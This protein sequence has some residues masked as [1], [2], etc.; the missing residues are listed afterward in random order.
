MLYGDLHNLRQSGDIDAWVNAPVND[1]M[2]YV[3]SIAPTREVTHQHVHFHI[4][5][6]TEVE[7]H[8]V[9]SEL[10]YFANNRRL[11]KFYN[12][13]KELIF[14]SSRLAENELGFSTP[15]TKFNLVF[16]LSHIYRHLFGEG[17]GLRQ[18]MDY[19]YLLKSSSLEERIEAF[20]VI[21]KTGMA[22]FC[23]ALMYVL[24]KIFGLEPD[25]YL[26][27]EEEKSGK[28]LLEDILTA[29]NFGAA[30]ER[31]SND[32]WWKRTVRFTRQNAH[33]LKYYPSEVLWDPV[34]RL[35]HFAWRKRHGYE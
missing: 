1:V 22:R 24:D 8:F 13:Q 32:N 3:N 16:Q 18:V 4:F 23:A 30:R 35:W 6:D 27:S 12:T 31:T 11:Q 20:D 10:E 14:D 29:G 5:E 28:V 34:W 15:T 25:Y 9:P 17:I 7:L 33:L 2:K 26:C 19:Y 21:R